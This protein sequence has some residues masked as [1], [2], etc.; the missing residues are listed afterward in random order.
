[1]P[2]DGEV[3]ARMPRADTAVVFTKRDVEHPVQS[4][5]S[6]PGELALP[7]FGWV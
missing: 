5:A 7:G 3:L 6:R 1:V 4:V 2:H